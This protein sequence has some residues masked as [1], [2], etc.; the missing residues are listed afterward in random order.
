MPKDTTQRI[1]LTGG[2]G[3][4][5][6]TAAG[7]LGSL[8]DVI[9][10]DADQISK[11]VT[12]SKGGAIPH[13]RLA[14]SSHYIHADGS[15][16]RGAMRELMLKD[17]AAK[18]RLEA[19]IHPLISEE[20]TRQECTAIAQGAKAIIFDIPLLVES[21]KWRQRVDAVWVIDCEVETQIQRVMQRSGWP[22]NQ[23][24]AVIAVQSTRTQRLLAADSVIY[25]QDLSLEDLKQELLV[26][27]R[28]WG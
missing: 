17:P 8:P 21:T 12:A 7:I 14:F 19:I 23:V 25:N 28:A 11:S 16:D 27:A 24:E 15:L 5:K 13:I 22:R 2:I 4:G 1:G 20:T 6:S 18:A 9:V 10:I 3:S 26:C